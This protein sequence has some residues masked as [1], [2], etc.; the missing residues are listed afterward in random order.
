M[1]FQKAKI[2]EELAAGKFMA[3]IVELACESWPSI[4]QGMKNIFKERFVIKDE[5]QAVFDLTLASIALDLQ[6]VRN[7]SQA[8]QGERIRS[9]I[10]RCL[11]TGE[12]GDYAISEIREYDKIFQ[13]GIESIGQ[14]EDPIC[15]ISARLL[16]RWLG[17]DLQKFEVV[18]GYKKTG[19][20][21]PVLIMTTVSVL[22]KCVGIWKAIWDAFEVSG[23]DLPHNFSTDHDGG[24][25][26]LHDY[27]PKSERQK[28]DGTIRYLDEHSHI[29]V[30]GA[31]PHRKAA[32]KSIIGITRGNWILLGIF[33]LILILY[34]SIRLLSN[35][36]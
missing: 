29:Q 7:L 5:T 15:A 6:A 17:S 28:P 11:N 20:I 35:G 22:M 8:S 26:G 18:V 25:L 34:A 33:I 16:N 2:T 32:N 23:S 21:D 4:H 27:Q 1:S 10:L 30:Q 14:S 9:W 3:K 24:A 19:A 31:G 13:L 36:P 12:Y